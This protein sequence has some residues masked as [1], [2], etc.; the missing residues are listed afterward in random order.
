MLK[1][2]STDIEIKDAISNGKSFAVVAGAGSGKTTSLVKALQFVQEEFGKQLL[3]NGKKIV[4]ITYT[5][6]AVRVIKQRLVE[7]Q[8]FSVSTIHSFVWNEIKYFQRDIKDLV[9]EY[10]IPARID[11]KQKKAIGGSKEAQRARKQIERLQDDLNEINNVSSFTYDEKS[12]RNYSTGK[13]D[14]DDVIDIAALMVEHLTIFKKIIRQKYPYIFI[15]ETQD[16]FE[17]IILALNSIGK[18]NGSVI[19]FFGDPK[20]QIYEKRAGEFHKV[21]DIDVFHK[22]ENYR[23]SNSVIKLLNSFRTDIQQVSAGN[24]PKGSVEIRLIKSDEPE[25][26]RKTY[27]SDQIEKAIAKYESALDYF[28]WRDDEEVKSLFLTRQMIATRLGFNKLNSLFNSQYASQNASNSFDDGTYFV[29][30][31]FINVIIP[32]VEAIKKNNENDKLVILRRTSP[33]L[34]PKGNN[35]KDSI[36]KISAKVQDACDELIKVWNNGTIKDVIKVAIE[37]GLILSTERLLDSFKREPITEVYDPEDEDHIRDKG[38]W[39][40]DELFNMDTSELSVYRDFIEDKTLYRTQHGV[41]GN[42]FKKVLV[43]F[44]DIEANW[45]NYSF[46]KLLTPNA[47]GKQPTDGQKVRTSNLA[48][49]CFSRTQEDLRIILFTTNPQ[50]SRTELLDAGLFD[51]TQITIQE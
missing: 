30:K 22:E 50:E 34:D 24:N 13:L 16:T 7:D 48:Y 4:C 11:K 9:R 12:G 2:T 29:L 38:E 6:E 19:G 35:A 25:G 26:P 14:H 3:V 46:T 40:V 8:I 51:N 43:V 33:I 5:N 20:Q 10:L 44:D 37:H 49:V 41:K 42:E 32:L 23:C 39:L 31:P 45:N 18:E 1:D 28:K 27:T 36:K 17:N 15:D 47:A 21:D